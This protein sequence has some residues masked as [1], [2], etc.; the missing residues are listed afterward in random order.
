MDGEGLFAATE[1]LCKLAEAGGKDM[2]A[3]VRDTVPVLARQLEADGQ[4]SDLISLWGLSS[5]S[6]ASDPDSA[7]VYPKLLEALGDLAGVDMTGEAVHAGLMHTYGYLLSNLET[8]FGFKRKRYVE[9]TVEQ[10]LGLPAGILSSNPEEGSLLANMSY[11]AGKI[12]G[13]VSE[14]DTKKLGAAESLRNCKLE[15]GERV[16]LSESIEA[17]DGESLSTPIELRTEL[18]RFGQGQAK[19]NSW[20]IYSQWESG[21]GKLITAFPAGG[22]MAKK[23]RKQGEKEGEVTIRGRYNVRLGPLEG[24]QLTG[25]ASLK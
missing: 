23:L 10:G 17:A 5:N 12:A 19:E 6:D 8:P 25:S 15:I 11:V 7:T 4:N 20:L 22:W 13:L 3:A 1:R 14:K 2:V 24:K 16:C 18:I 9:P 21:E